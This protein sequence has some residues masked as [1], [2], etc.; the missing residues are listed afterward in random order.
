M[1]I[2]TAQIGGFFLGPVIVSWFLTE[3]SFRAVNYVGAAC[4]LLALV[5]FIPAA[6]RLKGAPAKAG[7]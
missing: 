6:S 5:L 1:L 4:I 7:H 3:C 2:P